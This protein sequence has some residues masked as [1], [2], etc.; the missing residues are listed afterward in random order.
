MLWPTNAMKPR[1]KLNLF[2]GNY[3]AKEKMKMKNFKRLGKECVAIGKFAGRYA[4]GILG[5]GF[6][7]I[8]IIGA[9]REI[10]KSYK[11]TEVAKSKFVAE[12]CQIKGEST[13]QS[14]K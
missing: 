11:D 9:G 2:N 6:S 8:G 4:L 10:K 1:K 3:I 7:A 14:K 5:V 12:M 13:S